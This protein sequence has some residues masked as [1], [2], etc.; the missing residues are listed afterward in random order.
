MNNWYRIDGKT[1]C[2][3]S[4]LRNRL[5]SSRDRT[6]RT[7]SGSSKSTRN[8][9]LMRVPLG[10]KD[11]QNQNQIQ[12]KSSPKEEEQQQSNKHFH[13]QILAVDQWNHR[14]RSSFSIRR[15]KIPIW[16]A[17]LAPVWRWFDF[18]FLSIEKENPPS[19]CHCSYHI[20]IILEPTGRISPSLFDKRR[21]T[22]AVSHLHG[23][24]MLVS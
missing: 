3:K 9:L 14:P 10:K 16:L 11:K 19:R 13:N 20:V 4:E 18:I 23:D 7:L 8:G 12:K 22:I 21:E 17:L 6:S 2:S 15:K 5:R 1:Y 24:Q